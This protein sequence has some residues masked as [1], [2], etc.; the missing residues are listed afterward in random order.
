MAG[1]DIF[2]VLIEGRGGHGALPQE[3]IDPVVASAQIISALQTVVSRNISPLDTAVISVCTLRAGDAFNVI[4]QW[5]EFSGTFRTFEPAVRAKLIERFEKV[6]TG[7]A[8]SFGCQANVNIQRLTPPVINDPE[9]AELIRQAVQ[10][11]PGLRVESSFRTMISEDMAYMMEKAPGCYLMV[12][13]ANTEKGL[14]YGHHH[15]KF[16]FD[17]AV[18]PNAVAVMTTAALALLKHQ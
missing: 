14:N 15:P 8:E 7:L 12:G 2:D 1:A 17:E 3:S 5:A 9:A 6:V 11:I 16:D 18:L 4:P 13:S 10:Q